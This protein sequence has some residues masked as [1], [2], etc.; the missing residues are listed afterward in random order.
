LAAGA[1]PGEL[2]LTPTQQQPFE[3]LIAVLNDESHPITVRLDAAKALIPF[4]NFRKGVV[5]TAGRDVPVRV[6]IVRFSDLADELETNDR[7]IEHDPPTS[8]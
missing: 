3:F 5:D 6:T 4:T 7:L 8:H 1:A 2:V